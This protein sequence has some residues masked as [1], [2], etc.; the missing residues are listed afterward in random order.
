MSQRVEFRHFSFKRRLSLL[1]AGAAAFL[2]AY[3]I[4]AEGVKLTDEEVAATV[5]EFTERVEG[6]E[7]EGI[8]SNN[9]VIGLGM[10]IPGFGVGLGIYSAFST[11]LVFNA[12]AQVS[13]ELSGTSPLSL[14][15]TPFGILELSAYGIGISRSGILVVDLLKRTPW[16]RYIVITLIEIAIAVSAL[17]VGSFIEA[18]VIRTS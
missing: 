14:F 18:E 1:A 5:E 3:S 4:G 6:I 17:L 9:A 11:G 15:I 2:F 8:F 7:E 16:R 12:F 13:P 10:F